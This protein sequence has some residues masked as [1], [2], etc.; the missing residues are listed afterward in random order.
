MRHFEKKMLTVWKSMMNW[1]RGTTARK[2]VLTRF[3][4][5]HN[6]IVAQQNSNLFQ[7]RPIV[8]Q[9]VKPHQTWSNS[10]LNSLCCT[11]CLKVYGALKKDY[12]LLGCDTASPG[13]TRS[14][15]QSRFSDNSNLQLCRC[16]KLQ[17]SRKCNYDFWKLWASTSLVMNLRVG[18]FLT[19][20][21]S[22]SFSRKN[23]LHGVSK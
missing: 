7:N 11:K 18:D 23:L 8:A 13:T 1:W 16:E 9:P 14:T 3:K 19:S 20:W 15:T 5:L 21:E 22:V 2:H 10:L 4:L 6:L 17:N 12:G